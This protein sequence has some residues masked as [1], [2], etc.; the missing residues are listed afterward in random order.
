MSDLSGNLNKLFPKVIPP[1]TN[2]RFLVEFMRIEGEGYYNVHYSAQ[3]AHSL[4]GIYAR[5]IKRIGAPP[6]GIPGF[7]GFDNVE[8]NRRRR[9]MRRITNRRR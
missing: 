8:I 5:F 3:P 7:S 9:T 6:E 2:W 4:R 1:V